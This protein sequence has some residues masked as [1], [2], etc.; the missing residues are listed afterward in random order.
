MAETEQDKE[1]RSRPAQ[2]NNSQERN[3]EERTRMPFGG[4]T[5]PDWMKLRNS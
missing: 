5:R 4:I 2:E 3:S 1:D